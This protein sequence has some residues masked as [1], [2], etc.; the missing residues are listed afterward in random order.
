M[1]KTNQTDVLYVCIHCIYTISTIDYK[2]NII[3]L[4]KRSRV[5]HFKSVTSK[6]ILIARHININETWMFLFHQMSFL[7]SFLPPSK[8]NRTPQFPPGKI[9]CQKPPFR[10]GGSPRSAYCIIPLTSWAHSQV[11]NS[12]LEVSSVGPK[13]IVIN[14][15]LCIQVSRINGRK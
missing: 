10:N 5:L 2:Y 15:V 9:P 13:P 6:K 7:P 1:I 3:L 14:G 11:Q 8:K 4:T 12:F